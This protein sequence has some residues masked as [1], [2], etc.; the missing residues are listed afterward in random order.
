MKYPTYLLTTLLLLSTG[1][2]SQ[3]KLHLLPQPVS[4]T[5]GKGNFLIN[6]STTIL[7][8]EAAGSAGQWLQ[9]FLKYR[10]GYKIITIKKRNSPNS[11]ELQINKKQDSQIGKE[12]YRLSISTNGVKITANAAA[13]MWNGVQTFLQLFPADIE[14]IKAVKKKGWELPFVTIT[15]YPR[16]AWRGLMLDVSRHFFT[17]EEV[18]KMVDEMARYK[19]NILHLHLTDDQGWR[20]EI[21][22]YPA[23]T[24]KGA[25]RVPRTGLWWDRER[26]KPGEA[27]TYGGFYTQEQLKELVK[28]CAAKNIQVM[29]EIDV[30][31][32]SLAA[33]AAYPFLS[34]TKAAIDVNAGNLFNKTDDNAFCAGNDSSYRFLEKVFAEV[35]SIF[36]FEYI[37]VGGD[38]CNKSFWS[39]CPVCQNKK[40][41]AGFKDENELQSYFIRRVEKILEING[42][43]LMGWDEILEGGLAPNASVMSWRGIEG[44]IEAAKQNHPVVMTPTSHCYLDLFQGDPVIE[45]PTYSMLR[46][47]TV[48]GFEPVPAGVNEKLILGG[49]GNLWTE[50]VPQFRQ[51]EYMLWPRSLALAEVLWSPKSTRNWSEFVTRSEFQLQRLTA[52][53]INYANSFYDAIITTK[54]DSSGKLLIQLNTELDNLQLYYTFD[55]TYP[56]EYA[57]A[58]KK[59][60]AIAIAAD[61]DMFRVVTYRN[62][63]QA[64]RIITISIDALEKRTKK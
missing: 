58:Y 2:F 15:D 43:K 38:E 30:P 26:P 22:S 31:G 19:F 6:G 21:K 24:K 7:I 37:H 8:E 40:K 32:H 16:F 5:E 51:A 28:Y 55:N 46:F 36:P 41:D 4:I 25:W 18:K 53:G 12:G 20:M 63:K 54:R 13:G 33:A 42:K 45:P 44:G 62:G 59:D 61:A 35:A 1:L 17:M 52:A 39:K 64:G 34:C 9:T 29:P 3:N 14:A 56:D 60:D 23:L 57:T 27:V 10:T 50:S 11:I 47:K 48:Y 49:Q